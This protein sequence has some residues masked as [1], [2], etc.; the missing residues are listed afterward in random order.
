MID[1]EKIKRENAAHRAL[2]AAGYLPQGINRRGKCSVGKIP[3]GHS[4]HDV[5]DFWEF[6]SWQEAVDYLINKQGEERAYEN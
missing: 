4:K 6:D 3:D 1:R 5:L 2:V